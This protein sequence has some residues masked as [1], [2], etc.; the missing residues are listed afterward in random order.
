[1]ELKQLT[2]LKWLNMFSRKN[3]F[4]V[5][6]RKIDLAG[7]ILSKPDAIGIVGTFNN[8][9]VLLREYREPIGGFEWSFPAGLV[10]EGEDIITTAQREAKEETG[11]DLNVVAT[12]PVLPCSAGLTD[13]TTSYVIGEYSGDI[14]TTPGID[15]ERIEVHTVTRSDIE[16]IL[17]GSTPVSARAWPI[18]LQILHTGSF[19]TLKV[20]EC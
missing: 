5:S 2:N 19:F 20:L 12:S 4:F 9:L 16:Q 6:R 18:L 7:K 8:K 10:D 13:E 1:M 3:Y 14:S 15:N 17:Y 11:L